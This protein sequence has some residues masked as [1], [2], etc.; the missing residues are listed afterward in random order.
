[1]A[2]D[3]NN[4]DNDVNNLALIRTLKYLLWRQTKMMT[5]DVNDNSALI[6]H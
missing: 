3:Q 1:M 4:N 6:G 2:T 5:P